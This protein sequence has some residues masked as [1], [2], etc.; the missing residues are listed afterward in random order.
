LIEPESMFWALMAKD[1]D[2]GQAL[3]EEILPMYEQHSE[4]MKKELYKC[5]SEERFSAVYFNRSVQRQLPVLLPLPDDLR[6]QR[7]HMTYEEVSLALDNL[8]DFFQ[9]IPGS[10]AKGGK[11]P[12]IVFHRSEP[13]LV[14]DLLKRIVVDRADEFI[15]RIQTN[16]HHLD[17]ETAD[18]F[19]D[20]KVSL[21]ISL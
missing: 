1:R 7:H 4:S 20:N 14:K 16:S 10:V 6:D 8:H 13:L 11:K 3:R 9:N 5:R 18:N 19:M 2:L 21:G 17:D 12:V 15:F